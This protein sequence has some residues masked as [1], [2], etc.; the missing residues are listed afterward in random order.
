M[1]HRLTRRPIGVPRE[2]AA[3]SELVHR[4]GTPGANSLCPYARE[5]PK[6]RR[7]YSPV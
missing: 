7:S 1:G 4:A 6:G 3:G 5:A 2:P